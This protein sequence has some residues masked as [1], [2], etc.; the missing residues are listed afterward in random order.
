M[1]KRD[2]FRSS[3]TAVAK[4]GHSLVVKETRDKGAPTGSSVVGRDASVSMWSQ[5]EERPDD[6]TSAGVRGS[7]AR[8]GKKFEGKIAQYYEGGKPPFSVSPGNKGKSTF[9]HPGYPKLGYMARARR[10]TL[11][12]VKEEFPDELERKLAPNAQY[13]SKKTA[14]MTAATAERGLMAVRKKKGWG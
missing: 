3:E 8:S 5:D 10:R 9:R 14:Q 7:R 12:K 2:M 11:Q 1:M 6:F 4:I 13:G